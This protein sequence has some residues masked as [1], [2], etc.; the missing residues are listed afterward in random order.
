MKLLWALRARNCI[1]RMRYS[2][3]LML[4]YFP[5]AILTFFDSCDIDAFSG[6][7]ATSV[8]PSHFSIEVNSRKRSSEEGAEAPRDDSRDVCP[9]V[10][11]HKIQAWRPC[12]WISS[13]RLPLRSS[14]P[15]STDHRSSP[16]AHVKTCN[17]SNLLFTS[18]IWYSLVSPGLTFLSRHGSS[19]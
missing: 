15:F 2:N 7:T 12:G 1:H 3:A 14:A 6:N 9:G 17:P 18:V 16:Q 19:S 13:P 11:L 5:H 8:G 10:E 4:R